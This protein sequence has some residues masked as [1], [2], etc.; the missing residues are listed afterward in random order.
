MCQETARPGRG[1][2]LQVFFAGWLVGAGASGLI[3][4]ALFWGSAAFSIV[5]C[6]VWRLRRAPHALWRKCKGNQVI[7]KERASIFSITSP[8]TSMNPPME[9]ARSY[10]PLPKYS[11]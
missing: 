8:T 5:K 9:A 11:S 6:V 10:S 4:R 7:N 3:R 2:R 1:L